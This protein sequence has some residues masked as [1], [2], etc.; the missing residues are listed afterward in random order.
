[1]QRAEQDAPPTCAAPPEALEPAGVHRVH[2]SRTRCR[3]LVLAGHIAYTARWWDPSAVEGV[4][5]IAG[6]GSR[7]LGVPE[8]L[9]VRTSSVTKVREEPNVRSYFH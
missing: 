8:P 7:E 4:R 9:D 5:D 1:M 3:S 2:R 6:P